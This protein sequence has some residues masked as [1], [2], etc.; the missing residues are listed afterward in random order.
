MSSTDY[1]DDLVAPVATVGSTADYAADLGVKPAKPKA[2]TKA[3]PPPSFDTHD[4]TV[5]R[6]QIVRSGDPGV[7]AAF[8]QQFPVGAGRG[9][10]P[11]SAYQPPASPPPAA[12][13]PAPTA[14]PRAAPPAGNWL[15]KGWG[16]VQ[17]GANAIASGT[18]GTAGLIYGGLEAVGHNVVAAVTGD[19]QMSVE[20]RAMARARQ[21]TPELPKSL[22]T[23]TGQDYTE[24]VGDFLQ[25]NG[26]SLVGVGPEIAALGRVMSAKGPFVRA[27]GAA[28]VDRVQSNPAP[29]FASRV[30][31]SFE[32]NGSVQRAQP[33]GAAP[34]TPPAAT[35]VA[36]A[37][38]FSEAPPT[39][40]SGKSLS[41]AEQQ[42]RAEVLSS[43][44]LDRFRDSAITGNAKAAATEAQ[45][46]KV[47]SPAGNVMRA[48]LDAEKAALANHA[49]ELVKGTGGTQ[50]LDQSTL[51]GRG[52]TIV[53]PLDAL[54]EHFDAQTSALYKTAADRAQ[55]V[56]TDLGGFRQV[57]GD[58]SQLTNA[59][60]VH[61]RAA[62]NSYAK[63]LGMVGDDGSVFSNA[64]QAETMRQYLK[65]N[66]SPQNA[67]FVKNLTNALDQDVFKSAGED[68]YG[69]ARKMWAER[70][71]TLDNPNGIAKIMDA[72]G[73]EGIN[74]SVPI[75]KI[76]DA[77]AGMPVQQFGHI[78]DTLKGVPDAIQPQAQSALAEIKAHFANKVQAIGTSQ[79]GQWNAKGVTK[80]LN[81]NAERM[82]KVF[83][84]D[85][86]ARFQNLNDA[87]HIL[88]KDQSYPGA[89][90]QQH[91]LIRAGVAGGLTSAG[92]AVGGALA[93]PP[94]AAVGSWLGAKAG[95]ALNDA[96]S[97]RAAN[98]R[99]VSLK[100]LT[101]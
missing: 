29:A 100:D 3:S 71:N 35:G 47:D 66:W 92:G 21:F 87:G 9:L 61:L 55:G 28:A 8:D 90:V 97:L 59:D 42:R 48:Q 70:K 46:A 44:G 53:A 36:P 13:P 6:S 65:E 22:Q 26:P 67:G 91:N 1:A 50:G 94:G 85:E 32:P 15:D 38:T 80:F 93:G 5:M 74:R 82:A 81:N 4:P 14:A 98:A 7:L 95:T 43:V 79:A 72:N 84:P 68:V 20:D 19:P 64:Q 62:V 51:F 54:K 34:A 99:L 77:I 76:P 52:N 16:A 89:A 96:A 39:P 18:G 69:S 30:E 10:T 27:T 60:R 75:E 73:P 49:D 12:P 45:M 56:P 25:A 40:A 63:T 41:T 24:N 31:P 2:A 88:A 101:K 23:P 37:P 57:L 86:I 83:E 78:V 33:A 58:D 11:A 17:A